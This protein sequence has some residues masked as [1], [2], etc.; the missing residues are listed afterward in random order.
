MEGMY[1]E[2][3]EIGMKFTTPGRTITET[4][5]VLFT[6]I[7][8]DLS[9]L[10]T[11]EE[12]GKT[13]KYGQR[14]CHGML[15]VSVVTGLMTRSGIFERVVAMLGINNWKFLKP[16]F[17][18]DTVH[19]RFQ[20]TEKRLSNSNPQAGIIGRYYELINQRDEVIQKGEIPAMVLKQPE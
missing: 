16:L 18:G 11:N 8:G 4:D 14:L 5:L 2:D 20:I 1:Y 9:E 6:G 12:Y 19:V 15:G 3:F 7:S 10:H 17:V 13:T